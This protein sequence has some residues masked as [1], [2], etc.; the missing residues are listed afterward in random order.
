M[1]FKGILPMERFAAL[2][3]SHDVDVL[4][5]I[6]KSLEEYGLEANVARS[7]RE[8]NELLKQRRFD[9]AVCDYDLPGADQLAYLEPTS[10]WRGMVFAVVRPGHLTEL[11]GSRVHL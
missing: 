9:L 10:A 3:L 8:A 7:V 2:V 4:R 1:Y 11:H 6:N 5:I